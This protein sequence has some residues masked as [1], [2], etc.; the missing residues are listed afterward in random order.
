[1][2]FLRKDK[3]RPEGIEVSFRVGDADELYE[4]H[5][6]NGV[7]ITV[8]PGDREYGIRDYGIVDLYGYRLVFGHFLMPFE[9]VLPIERVSLPVRREKRLA[10]VLKDLAAHKRMSI[11]SC[12]EET[13]LHT[14]EPY[15]DG[16]A[17]P[18]TKAQLRHIQELK[19]KH[20]IDYDS[21]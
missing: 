17:S 4:F 1:E 18:H 6:A 8:P 15:G 2:V 13:L 14:F 20:G 5:R 12:L 16:V 21:H 11:D 10:A 9:P 19:E 7:T 3:A